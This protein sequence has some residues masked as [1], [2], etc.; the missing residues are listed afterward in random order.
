M[1]WKNLHVVPTVNRLCS[2]PRKRAWAWRLCVCVCVCACVCACARKEWGLGTGTKLFE[3][4]RSLFPGFNSFII[5]LLVHIW[6]L[7]HACTCLGR[8]RPLYMYRRGEMRYIVLFLC[9]CVIFELRWPSDVPCIV[10]LCAWVCK[11][12][13]LLAIVHFCFIVRNKRQSHMYSLSIM[14]SPCLWS[15]NVHTDWAFET[16]ELSFIV[17]H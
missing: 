4:G 15:L 9:T 3:W 16:S 1:Y 13:L 5:A 17:A 12:M 14:S 6:C 11:C 7:N 8:W 2:H 10:Y